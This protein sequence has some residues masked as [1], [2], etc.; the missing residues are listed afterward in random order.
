LDWEYPA[1]RDTEDRPDDKIYFTLLCKDLS[2]A[3][4]PHSFILTAAVAAGKKYIE[5]GYELNEI[6]QY[7]DFINIMAYV[8]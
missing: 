3:F 8:N 1:N 5:T 2:I 7:L 6:H 4:K